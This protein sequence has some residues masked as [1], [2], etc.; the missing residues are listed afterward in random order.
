MQK[1]E[2]RTTTSSQDM[3]K[4]MDGLW[5]V[6]GVGQGSEATQAA[7]RAEWAREMYLNGGWPLSTTAHVWREEKKQAHE[8]LQKKI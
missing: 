6:S 5:R 3:N 7:N 1:A 4:Y 8:V 2:Y